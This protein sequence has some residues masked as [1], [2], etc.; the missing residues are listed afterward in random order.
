MKKCKAILLALTM[1]CLLAGTAVAEE[2][3]IGLDVIVAKPFT[4]TAGQNAELGTIYPGPASETLVMDVSGCA[5][6]PGLSAGVTVANAGMLAIQG[7][8]VL[9]TT[10]MTAGS[11]TIK[12]AIA[13]L[14][15][16]ATFVSGT[17]KAPASLSGTVFVTPTIPVLGT[18]NNVAKWVS[19]TSIVPGD[20][21]SSVGGVAFGPQL[22]IASDVKDATYAGKMTVNIFTK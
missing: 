7:T 20:A 13:G 10:G 5:I 1:V 11:V 16:S 22:T 3:E 14:D 9:V 12:P 15:L 18:R 19:A 6:K 21:T 2:V 4:A 8:N 17:L